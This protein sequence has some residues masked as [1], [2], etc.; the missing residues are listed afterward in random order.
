MSFVNISIQACCGQTRRP[1][2]VAVAMLCVHT[3]FVFCLSLF[4]DFNLVL[5][6]NEK[7][8]S[9]PSGE[10]VTR[11]VR[12]LTCRQLKH[13][14]GYGQQIY[15]LEKK[16]FRGSKKQNWEEGNRMWYTQI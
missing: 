14:L 7:Q 16:T 10:R 5:S 12:R 4:G 13:H 8:V 6:W 2:D 9:L 15:L 11:Q 1:S 3:A